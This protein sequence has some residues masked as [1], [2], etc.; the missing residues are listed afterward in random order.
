M[1]LA[2]QAG[3]ARFRG[4]YASIVC[5]MQADGLIEEASL[6]SHAAAVAGVDGIVGLLVNGHAGENATLSREEARAVVRLVRAASPRTIVV[7]G[8]NAEASAAA[9]DLAH[10]A[11]AEGADAIMVF[12]PFSWALGVDRRSIVRH[13]EIIAAATRLPI[14]LFQGSVWSGR[15]AYDADTLMALLGLPAVIAIKEGSWETSAY[16]ATRR[17][18]ARARPEVL[19]MASGDEHLLSTFMLGSEGSLVSLAAVVPELVVGL[20]R[21]VRT[22]DLAAALDFH[23][24]LGPLAEAVYRAPPPGLV[25][26]RLKACL[27]VLGRLPDPAVRAPVGPLST[28]ETAALVQALAA[29][30]VKRKESSR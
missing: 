18:V 15:L 16:E 3:C 20:D 10:E 5:P 25:A 12:A 26:A 29:A 28:G 6:R 1:T 24:R 2:D 30:G 7:A 19:V 9:A 27:H 13:H 23:R 21:A 17:M 22:G 11:E 8:V 14:F 4:I